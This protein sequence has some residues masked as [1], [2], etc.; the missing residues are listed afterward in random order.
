M[1][2]KEL[3]YYIIGT[4]D[5]NK[6]FP[7]IS[8]MD[9]FKNKKNWVYIKELN[10]KNF[11]YYYTTFALEWIIERIIVRDDCYLPYEVTHALNDNL[12][13]IPCSMSHV[14]VRALHYNYK[15]NVLKDKY[16]KSDLLLSYINVYLDNINTK[17]ELSIKDINKFTPLELY[18]ELFCDYKTDKYTESFRKL[19][20]P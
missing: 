2:P 17:K 5:Y 12:F 8:D 6:I 4:Y 13:N 10:Y 20:I 15:E 3:T 1:Y 7:C 14:F 19:F 16:D 9:D 18:D 11:K